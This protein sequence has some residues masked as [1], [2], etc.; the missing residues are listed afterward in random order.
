M[1]NLGILLMSPAE[2][3]G[4]GGGI[5]TLLMFGLIFIVFYF[6]MIRPQVKKQKEQKK[7]REALGKGDRIVTI[8]GIHGKIAELKEDTVVIEVEGGN[9][10]KI[11][12]SA[13][14]QEFSSEEMPQK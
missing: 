6:F 4:D 10:L 8:G 12:K 14:A 7:F 9:R 13:I 3:A 11:E 2:G 1:N 5:Q